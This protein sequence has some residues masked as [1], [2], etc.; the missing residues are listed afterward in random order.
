MDIRHF[1]DRRARLIARMDSVGG[2]GAILPTATE[3][4]RNRD[5]TY[6]YRADS[7]FQY[8]TGFTEPEAVLVLVAGESPKSI[9]FC[10]DRDPDKEIWDGYRY[11]P[12]GALEKF[13]FDEAHSIAALDEKLPGLIANQPSLWHS[14]GFE[15]EWDARIG[16]ALNAVRAQSRAGKRA[17][18]SVHDLR[19]AL[20]E[21]R[22]IKGGQEIALSRRAADIA[23]AAHRRAMCAAAPGRYEYEIEAEFL[24]EF[25]RQGSQFPA[26]TTIVASGPGACV[27]HYVNNDRRM[28]DGELLL[29]DA[30]CEL[31]GYASDIT[32]TF[33]VNG[34]F[35]GPQEDVY[36][37]VEAA[38]AAAIAAIRPGVHFMAPHEAAVKVLA[39][40]MIDLKLL[41]GS[42]DAVIESESYKRFYMHRTSHWLGMDVHDVGDYKTGDDWRQL[43]PGMVL[44]VEPGCY[45]RPAD[46]VPAAF[47]DIGIHIEDDALVTLNGCEIL[48]AAAPKSIADIEALMAAAKS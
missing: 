8:L 44:T 12:E 28:Q 20:D 47:H 18:T 7:Y 48:T 25:R 35:S 27:L 21:M 22:L 19:A 15:P 6:P 39:Q 3:K 5:A 1:L 36:E 13:G 9:L 24:H 31:D 2:G 23:A 41:H 33:P 42:V 34:R 43:S 10:R 11:G 40:G 29:I 37:L 38:Q 30:G 32:R 14:L 26:Y 4:T 46:D 45:I 16:R 17:P